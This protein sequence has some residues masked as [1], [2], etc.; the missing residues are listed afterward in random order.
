MTYEMVEYQETYQAAWNEFG[1]THGSLFHRLEWKE[2][3]EEA[4]GYRS[5]YLLVLDE[6]QVV[7]GLLPLCTGRNLALQRV[8]VSLP[9][10][11]Y[12]NICCRDDEVY[13][14]IVE[15]LALLPRLYGLSYLEV[16]LKDG[17][18]PAGGAGLNDQNATFILPLD[19]DEAAILA[20]ASSDN[21]R[22][23]RLVYQKD[24]FAVSFD[25]A[26]LPAFYDVYRR[27]QKQLGSPAAA[28]KL[29]ETIQRKLPDHTI[30]LT[31]LERKTRQVV[32]GMFLL[33][34]NKTIYYHW[35]ATLVEY[36]AHHLNHFM[37]REAIKFGLRENYQ[38]LDLGRSPTTPGHSG[39]YG[40]KAQFGA[41]P[42]PLKYY[43][44]GP[45]YEGHWSNSHAKFEP[46]IALWK[47]LPA[48]LTD[49]AGRAL[50]KHVMP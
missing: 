10:V 35:G 24:L 32:G 29:F 9:F 40:F 23:T 48:P 31:V 16:R 50:I 42:A 44:F 7:A 45:G 25:K 1:R 4:C 30:L 21:R 20:R 49:V 28:I 11:H 46:L 36:N 5:V 37:Y 12:V 26:H 33:A 15:R 13:R 38:Y 47:R 22:R 34:D 18:I 3:L 8:G 39:T 27:R 2:I 43:R 41:P 19:G 17:E 14:F 6:R